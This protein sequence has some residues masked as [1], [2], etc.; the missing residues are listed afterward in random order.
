MVH[1][2]DEILPLL[3]SNAEVDLGIQI[4]WDGRVWLCVNGQ[5]FLRFKPS[6]GR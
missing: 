3:E 1:N 2:Q 4:A 6:P 5:A